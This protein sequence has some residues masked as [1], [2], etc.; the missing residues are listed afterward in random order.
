MARWKT[1]LLA[2]ALGCWPALGYAQANLPVPP[3]GPGGDLGVPALPPGANTGTISAP[4]AVSGSSMN[5]PARVSLSDMG[6][7]S[8]MMGGVP[9][10]TGMPKP[11]G[12]MFTGMNM[13]MAPMMGGDQ[14]TGSFMPAGA[15]SFVPGCPVGVEPCGT[16]IHAS[17]PSGFMLDAGIMWYRV[18]RSDPSILYRSFIDN[19][20]FGDVTVGVQED[21]SQTTGAGWWVGGG[22]LAP[23]GW[24]GM[25]TYRKYTD[26]VHSDR[27]VNDGLDPNFSIEYIG[28]G[29]LG[30]GA[31]GGDV[32]GNGFIDRGFGVDWTNI[33]L[34][35]G[36]V[37]SPAQC[38][39]LVFSGGVRIS[40]LE[41]N[42]D[43]FI[44]RDLGAFNAQE[45]Y[46]RLQGAGPRIGLESRVYPI[47][48]LT[49]YAKAYTSLLYTNRVE[50]ATTV[51]ADGLGGF[52]GGF[53]TYTREEL[54]P[55]LELSLGFDLNLFSGRF[56]IGAG[57]D[58]NYLWE[59]G[60]TYSEQTT[61][62]RSA[63]HVNLAIDGV[64]L[65][66]TWLW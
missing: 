10:I 27:V 36:T 29:P 62:P 19:G 12:M 44:N 15:N 42:Y 6:S 14:A 51:F 16:T 45:L 5:R 61:N 49:L 39:D 28:P 59:A 50:E 8:G 18:K 60:S 4:V 58:F 13:G 55:V 66:A 32:P 24:F 64:N 48:P 40:K 20:G 65:H 54:M 53:T 63:R 11:E 9:D 30:S 34:M 35:V 46:T 26:T 22:Y 31:G 38:L 57:Y 56:I 25:V 52:T 37:I 43:V 17:G 41:Q 21:Y 33:D 3:A 7:G 47:S 23:N 2:G 1:L